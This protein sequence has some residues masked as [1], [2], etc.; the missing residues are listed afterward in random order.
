MEPT[1]GSVCIYLG[2]CV[3]LYMS[4]L[5]VHMTFMHLGSH[6]YVERKLCHMYD[7]ALK[8]AKYCDFSFYSSVLQP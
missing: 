4:L 3:Y 7:I 8:N 6:K 2:V 1:S 5:Y